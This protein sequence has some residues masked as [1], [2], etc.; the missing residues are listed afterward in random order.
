MILNDD[1][2]TKR[3]ASGDLIKNHAANS[4]RNCACTLTAGH[5]FEATSGLK[6][7]LPLTVAGKEQQFWELGPS[8]TLVVMTNEVIKLP[9]DLCASYAP[10]YRLSTKGVMLLNPA[11]VE[12]LYEGPLS[13][14]LV[15]FSSQRVRIA[16]GDPVSK[17]IFN[18]LTAPPTKPQS[19]QILPEKYQL[20][21]SESATKF[22]RSFLDVSGIEERAAEKARAGLKGWAI[23]GGV[24]L[25]ALV[26][27]S[28]IEPFV[29]KWV[30]EKTGVVTSTQRTADATLIKDLESSRALL[31]SET[32][33]R[34]M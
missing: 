32:Q 13:C 6:V 26:A 5:V 27:F 16:K 24:F 25:A 34:E 8:E 14:V 9:D 21:L 4:I 28:T 7:G 12:P 33:V 30:F 20:S 2:I 1:E 18:K 10:L 23:G 11:V 29:S 15:N 19:Q 22:H 17:I 31:Q 3:V